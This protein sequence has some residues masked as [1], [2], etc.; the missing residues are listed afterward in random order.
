MDA[1]ELLGEQLGRAPL[2][3]GMAE[4]PQQADRGGLGVA[5]ALAQ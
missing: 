1:V 3:L 5:A 2:V 4:A